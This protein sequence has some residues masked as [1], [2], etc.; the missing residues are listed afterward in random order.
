V[1][2][3]REKGCLHC[4]KVFKQSEI[5]IIIDFKRPKGQPRKN[6]VRGYLCETCEKHFTEYSTGKM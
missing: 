1:K 4:G 3:D 2:V 5:T 6:W